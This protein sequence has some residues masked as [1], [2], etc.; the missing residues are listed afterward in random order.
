MKLPPNFKYVQMDNEL[1]EKLYHEWCKK[2]RLDPKL[3]YSVYAFF[4]AIDRIP[5]EEDVENENIALD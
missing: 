5:P 3:E 4:D 1:R 2:E